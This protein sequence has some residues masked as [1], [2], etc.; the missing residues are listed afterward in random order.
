MANQVI[1]GIV[2]ALVCIASLSAA[3]ART[4]YDGTW[5]VLIVTETGICDRAYRYGVE[6]HNGA[7]RYQG[8]G[9]IDLVGRVAQ[10]GSVRVSVTSG[11]QYAHGS[12]R[13]SRNA[14]RGR[15]SGRSNT[16]ACSGYWTAE[17][18]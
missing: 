15:W 18:R 16:G 7:V 2:F 5:S 17:R 10:N 14:G 11:S 8:G 12:G 4:A 13:M 6:I 9:P 1:R 3:Q